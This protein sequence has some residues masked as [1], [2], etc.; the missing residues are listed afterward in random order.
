[1]F[2]TMQGKIIIILSGFIKKTQKTPTEEIELARKRM[3]E[4]KNDE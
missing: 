2:C 1:M 4:I 3:Q